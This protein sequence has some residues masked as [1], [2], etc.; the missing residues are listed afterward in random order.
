MSGLESKLTQAKANVRF[1]ILCL[2][3]ILLVTLLLL[4]IIPPL[5]AAEASYFFRGVFVF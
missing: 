2:V 1:G 4:V 3:V 5:I